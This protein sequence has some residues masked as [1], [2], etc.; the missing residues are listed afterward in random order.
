[1]KIAICGSMSFAKEML[2]AAK[3]LE[4]I[5]HEPILPV[6]TIESVKDPFRRQ[7]IDLC[8]AK[9]I[10]RDHMR[11]IQE[12]DAILVLNYKKKGIA[13]YVGGSSL[14]EMGFAHY[15]NKKIYLLNP[16]P[17]MNYTVEIKA[18]QPIVLNGD[19]E[20]LRKDT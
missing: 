19:F 20:K 14:I 16:F 4:D 3:L 5:G 9:D 2:K 10:I 6:D 13:G 15:L 18:M 17:R 12:S 11:K 8:I 1:M 7:N